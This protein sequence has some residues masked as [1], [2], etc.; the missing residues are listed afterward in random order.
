MEFKGTMLVVKDIEKT[1]AFYT[2]LL[3]L[4]IIG[5]LG[6]NVAFSGG[7]AAQT[8]ASWT[9]FTG[10]EQSVFRYGGHDKELYFE[11]TDFDG[12]AS[13]VRDAGVDIVSETVMPYGQKVLRFYDPDKHIVEVG[14]DMGVMIRRLYSEGLTKE[15]IMERTFMPAEA[16]DHFMK[17]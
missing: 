8:E 9:A 5:D 1:K 2:S 16:I 3:G 4:T 17:G 15:Q 11:E 14:E 10:S 13:K 6:V 7:L 12:F